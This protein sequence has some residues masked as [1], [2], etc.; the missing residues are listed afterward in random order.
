LENKTSFPNVSKFSDLQEKMRQKLEGSRFRWL[1][2]QLYTITGNK[3]LELFD[4]DPNLFDV[5]HQGFRHQV[6]KWPK[7]PVDIFIN[8]IKSNSSKLVIADFGCGDAKIAQTVPNKVYSFDLQASNSFVT[9]CDISQVPLDNS[10]VDVVIFSLSLMGTNYIDFLKEAHR[11]L[12]SNGVLKIAEVK[13]RFE[14]INQ[15]VI[16]LKHLGLDLISKDESNKMF[17]LF[18]FKK[19]SNLKKIETKGVEIPLKICKYK[20]R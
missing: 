16:S 20:K 13:S 6:T 15:F 10:C 7:N 8:Y 3:A 12:K 5:Y 18:E 4:E 19:S 14:D 17:I 9:K 2:E 1:N 11:V